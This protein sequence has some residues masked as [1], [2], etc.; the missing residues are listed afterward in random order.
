MPNF[1]EH[2]TTGFWVTGI[3]N[4]FASAARQNDERR[5][6]LR[7]DVSFWEAVGDG[8]IGGTGGALGSMIPDILDPPTN[9][10]HRG[11][12]HS[13]WNLILSAGIIN[14]NPVSTNSKGNIFLKSIAGGNALHILQDSETP[15][16]IPII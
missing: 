11:R 2:T 3:I 12:F 10:N 6:G 13:I 8:L 16:G 15:R 4:F 9:P 1:K 5:F 14:G 7:S